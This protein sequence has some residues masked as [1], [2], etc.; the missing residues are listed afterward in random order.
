[1]SYQITIPQAAY[2]TFVETAESAQ[3]FFSSRLWDL[4]HGFSISIGDIQSLRD[5]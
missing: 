4:E 1:M 5:D 3:L 2:V